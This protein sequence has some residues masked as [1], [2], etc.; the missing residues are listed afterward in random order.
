MQLNVMNWV[1]SGK[2]SIDEALIRANNGVLNKQR[3]FELEVQYE[4]CLKL[5]T[6]LLNED[7]KI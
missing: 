7:L 4:I 2:M 6:F 1:K 3:N 5:L